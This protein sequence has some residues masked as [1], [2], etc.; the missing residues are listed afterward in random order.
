MNMLGGSQRTDSVEYGN[1]KFEV[2]DI[3]NFRFADMV[4]ASREDRL[5]NSAA[6]GPEQNDIPGGAAPPGI[7]L[8]SGSVLRLP[9]RK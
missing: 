7:F 9:V 6:C 1:H 2:V 8:W 3:D 4:P 5:R